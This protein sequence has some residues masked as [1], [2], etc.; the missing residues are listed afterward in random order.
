M[1]TATD[2]VW[3]GFIW[4]LLDAVVYIAAYKLHNAYGLRTRLKNFWKK[5]IPLHSNSTR[6]KKCVRIYRWICNC[7]FRK[8]TDGFQFE[9]DCWTNIGYFLKLLPFF[10]FSCLSLHI[11]NVILIENIVNCDP[12]KNWKTTSNFTQN[13]EFKGRNR[14]KREKKRKSFGIRVLR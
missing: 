13:T 8:T 6:W 5:M 9:T 1:S 2:T 7:S 14:R 4:K 11:Y 12:E 3:G 10:F